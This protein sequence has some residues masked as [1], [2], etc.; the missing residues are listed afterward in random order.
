MQ[1]IY[2]S[3]QTKLTSQPL[4]DAAALPVE[5]VSIEIVRERRKNLGKLVCK[6]SMLATL[7]V[8]F[9]CSILA[10]ICIV[11]L[12]QPSSLFIRP[13]S[14][15]NLF[16]NNHTVIIHDDANSSDYYVWQNDSIESSI[17]LRG[18]NFNSFLVDDDDG[19]E[20]ESDDE[21]HEETQR[22]ENK[23]NSKEYELNAG[24]F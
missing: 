23:L 8:V 22:L 11:N 15:I 19:D 2:K 16:D 5:Q 20:E 18:Q 17:P 24:N 14:I 13:F 6:P 7:A 12:R 10:I 4:F 1:S 21:E 3:Y 9:V